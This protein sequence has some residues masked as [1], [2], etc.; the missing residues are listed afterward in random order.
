MKYVLQTNVP[1]CP[2]C[3]ALLFI[4]D[5][6]GETYFCCAHCNKILKVINT[7]QSDSEVVVSDYAIEEEFVEHL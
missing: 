5:R 4:R 2:R 3:S 1:R 6:N 7:N